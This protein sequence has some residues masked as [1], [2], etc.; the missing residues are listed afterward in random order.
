MTREK[1]EC[2]ICGKEASCHCSHCENAYCDE[3]YEKVVMT[4]NCCRDNE[5]DYE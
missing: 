2:I 3:C 5:R 4:G 1:E